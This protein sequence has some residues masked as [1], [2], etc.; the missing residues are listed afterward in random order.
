MYNDRDCNRVL[1]ATES[2]NSHWSR[3]CYTYTRLLIDR[4]ACHQLG[5]DITGSDHHQYDILYIIYQRS[6][7]HE[8]LISDQSR[9]KIIFRSVSYYVIS[10]TCLQR[11][12]F[13]H[14]AERELELIRNTW[15]T[16]T[17]VH[18]SITIT[19]IKIDCWHTLKCGPRLNIKTVL[20][21]RSWDSHIFIMEIPMRVGHIYIE[22][23][24]PTPHQPSTHP[25][26]YNEKANFCREYKKYKMHKCISKLASWVPKVWI[27]LT[28]R[29]Q[30]NCR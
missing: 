6:M 17:H 12:L 23:P 15:F 8:E 16:F 22:N 28:H 27:M 4:L 21:R 11:Y 25:R 10:Q 9:A 2:V 30:L 3:V 1:R 19:L 26:H 14:R 5:L 20:I 18:V 29:E 7:P 13:I 24:K